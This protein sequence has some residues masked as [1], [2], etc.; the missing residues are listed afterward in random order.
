MM[1]HADAGTVA[2]CAV[3][4]HTIEIVPGIDSELVTILTRLSELTI[5]WVESSSLNYGQGVCSNGFTVTTHDVGNPIGVITTTIW[6]RDPQARVI[7][8]RKYWGSPAFEDYQHDPA[9]QGYL[10][11][12]LVQTL[13]PV[14]EESL[15]IHSDSRR[16]FLVSK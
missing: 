12:W 11:E 5:K 7:F 14:V 6:V 2:E 10:R 3:R 16:R 15:R 8:H 4:R 13:R 9:S 1:A